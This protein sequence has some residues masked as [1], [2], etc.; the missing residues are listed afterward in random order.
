MFEQLLVPEAGLIAALLGLFSLVA[1]R[2][3]FFISVAALGFF[4]AAQA[5]KVR[6]GDATQDA[7]TTI[8]LLSVLVGIAAGVFT[9]WSRN[10]ALG[11]AGYTIAG[12]ILSLNSSAWGLT[13]PGDVRLSFVLGGIAGSVLTAFA[14]EAGLIGLSSLLGAHLILQYFS[15]EDELRKW[16]MLLL[17]ILG[18]F[19]QAGVFQKIS[20]GKGKEAPKK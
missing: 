10:A 9:K 12:Y 14:P 7:R 11:I 19:I 5:A 8:L 6:I 18:I 15:L 16:L 20:A 4:I 3:Y 13:A 17:T 1:G 2:K